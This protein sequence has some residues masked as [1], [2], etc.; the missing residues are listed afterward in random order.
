[1]AKSMTGYGRVRL[2]GGGWLQNWEIRSV[3][4]RYL[5][6]K[7]RLPQEVRPLEME[8]E[9]QVRK[10]AGRG[11][12]EITL[13]LTATDIVLEGHHL[14]KPMALAMLSAVEEL[15][16]ERGHA[17]Q[18][19]YS[20]LLST[21]ALWK[22]PGEDVDEELS[23]LAT[24]GLREALKAWDASREKEGES[25]LADLL[26]RLAE[27]FKLQ[28]AIEAELPRILEQKKTGLRERLD[29]L[30]AEAGAEF[31]EQRLLQEV[32][33]LT[34]RLDVSEEM[35]R[36]GAHLE[37]IKELFSSKGEAGKRL[38]FLLQE[39]FREINTCGN[40]AQD[41]EISRLVVE[42]KAELE[43]CR[44]QAQNME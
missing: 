44:E 8:L 5:D 13:D 19:D 10:V 21:P 18:P 2:E 26:G 12:L 16:Q 22:D 29:A 32:A 28:A 25:L 4:G 6:V 27:L 23:R 36:L 38:D 31:D 3:N 34:D 42:F 14:N 7:W 24:E 41:A 33:V 40:K 35:S 15:A 37:R 20:K 17:F 11:R 9:R 43:K 39:C 1:M 30:M